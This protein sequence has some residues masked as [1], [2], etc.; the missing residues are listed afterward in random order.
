MCNIAGYVGTKPAA[1]ILIDMLRREEGFCGGYFTGIAT[2]HEGK[3]YYAKLTGDL[4]HLVDHTNAADLPGTIGIIHSRSN[5]G[6]GDEWAHPFVGT[7][8]G[9]TTLAYVA[10]G[11]Q[12][13]F[14]SRSAEVS[15]LTEQLLKD[16]YTLALRKKT[17]RDV[18]AALPD[19][20]IAHTSDVMCQLIL[21]NMKN[22]ADATTAMADAFCELPG[23]I[24]GLL[25]SLTTPDCISWSRISRP[26]SLSF[27]TH[28]AYLATTA[29]A[30][31][32]DAGEP[33]LLPACSAG[34][35]YSNRFSVT[36][37]QHSP[38]RIAPIHAQI[39]HHAYEIICAE[40]KNG[41]KIFVDLAQA[42]KPL[43]EEADCL[44]VAALVYDILYGL[45]KCGTLKIEPRRIPGAR[46]DLDAPKFFMSIHEHASAT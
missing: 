2:L 37:Y 34:R 33:Q 19:G 9:E 21:R 28:G 25:L 32:E 26:M 36:P 12:G 15:T 41:P 45:K 20:S 38:A 3:I 17:D 11:A 40:L 42:I 43:F 39:R 5:A 31:P 24:V 27:T 30:F 14:A 23:E 4:Q 29:M 7:L 13:Y 8:N 46:A 35:V 22:G 44:P 16:G 1:P 10:N 18:Y 6:G